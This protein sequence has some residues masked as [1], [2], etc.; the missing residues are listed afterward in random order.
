[1][2][3]LARKK[4]LSPSTVATWF[5]N[6]D[7]KISRL[8]QIVDTLEASIRFDIVTKGDATPDAENASQGSTRL[9]VI[10]LSQ[11]RRI[12]MD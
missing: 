9:Y 5:Q 7:L 12:T 6:D 2:T 10:N 8:F 1:M 3:R 11:T 4:N